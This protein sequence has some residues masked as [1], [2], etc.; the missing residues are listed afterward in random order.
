M[1]SRPS[2]VTRIKRARSQVKQVRF[3]ANGQWDAQLVSGIAAGNTA[4]FGD[5]LPRM[6]KRCEYRDRP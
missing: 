1:S 2:V 5:P 3:G 4:T 6:S